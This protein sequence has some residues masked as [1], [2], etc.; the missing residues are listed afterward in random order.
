MDVREIIIGL[1]LSERAGIIIL[2]AV[3][4]YLMFSQMK[5]Q[6]ILEKEIKA[7]KS[8]LDKLGHKSDNA[9]SDLS[10]LNSR[11][12]NLSGAV[13]DANN[14]AENTKKELSML[15]DGINSE[16][17]FN[18]AIEMARLGSSSDDITKETGLTKDQVDTIVRFHGSEG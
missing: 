17:I 10:S 11:I 9:S 2:L 12:S 15:A 13:S 3:F 6:T 7:V 14:V 16:T 8:K 4:L 5:Q 18:K 1:I